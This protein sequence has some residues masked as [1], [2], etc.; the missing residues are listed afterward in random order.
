MLSEPTAIILIGP[1]GSGK[2]TQSARLSTALGIPKIST[3][4]ILRSYISDNTPL[5]EK[6]N[7]IIASGALVPDD[8]LASVIK[9][10]LSALD[11][12]NGFILDG[13]PRSLQQATFL[14]SLLLQKK[15]RLVV[16][17]IIV[18]ESILV[19][20][21]TGRFSCKKCG[22]IYNQYFLRPEKDGI[23]DK[24][25]SSDFYHRVDDNESV[26]VDRLQTYYL[27]THPLID[28][29]DAKSVVCKIDGNKDSEGVYRELLSCILEKNIVVPK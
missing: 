5:S 26:I 7:K 18:P 13:Y 10:R 22:A 15:Y 1:P 14:E 21:V 12:E 8:I 17:E 29:Y 24:C 9:E 2:G 11:C 4:D 20:R 27:Q 19:K 3:G 25:G 23:C 16:I 6:I 28:F